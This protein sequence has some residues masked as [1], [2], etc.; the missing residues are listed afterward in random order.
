MQLFLW[1][2][3]D[4]DLKVVMSRNRT[5]DLAEHNRFWEAKSVVQQWT[6]VSDARCSIIDLGPVQFCES[7]ELAATYITLM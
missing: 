7:E 6:T 5:P 4:Q 1:F 2:C 3:H